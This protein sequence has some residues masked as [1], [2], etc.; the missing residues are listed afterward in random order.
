M[1]REN[2]MV[3]WV[4]SERGYVFCMEEGDWEPM[5]LDT[6]VHEKDADDYINAEIDSLE[7]G[8]YEVK[9][10]RPE[11][12]KDDWQIDLANKQKGENGDHDGT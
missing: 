5:P 11:Y 1:S 3:L 4:W 7:M 2:K 6:H 10:G 8:G 12:L 9:V